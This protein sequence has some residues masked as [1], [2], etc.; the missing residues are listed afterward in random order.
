MQTHETFDEFM[1]LF[2]IVNVFLN[3]FD[4]MLLITLKRKFIKT[5]WKNIKYLIDC[6]FYNVFVDEI[7]SVN[8]NHQKKTKNQKYIDFYSLIKQ[9]KKIK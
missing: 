7:K 9:L 5:L 1:I 2:T 3:L 4:A 8:L 6:T